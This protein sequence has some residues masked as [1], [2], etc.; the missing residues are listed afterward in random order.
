MNFFLSTI[1][2]IIKIKIDLHKKTICEYEN[3]KK[4]AYENVKNLNVTNFNAYHKIKITIYV[5]W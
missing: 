2:Y 5:Y 4:S 3:I 1:K